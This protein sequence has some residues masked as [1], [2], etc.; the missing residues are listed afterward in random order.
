[1]RVIPVI[2]LM[3]GQVVRGVAGNR[4]EYRPIESQIAIDARPKTVA[5]ALVERFEFQTVY[6]AD[7]DAIRGGSPNLHAWQDISQAG[8][9]LW[10]DAGLG[11]PAACEAVTEMLRSL[12]IEAHIIIGLES[13]RDPND[14]GWKSVLSQLPDLIFSLD[15]KNGVPIHRIN[16]WRD[17]SASEIARSAHTRGFS[18][19]I[20]LDLADVGTS[21]GTRTLAL[22]RL[23]A[24]ELPSAYIIAGGGVRGIDDLH[25]LASAGCSAALVA[26]ALHDGRLS[27]EDIRQM[28]S[29]SVPR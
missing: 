25:A 19:M 1:M 14:E 13:L 2:D 29:L 26:S 6:I 4:S 28:E 12:K 10:I 18:N 23:L 22:C 9:S 16:A 15:L 17:W 27:A 11:D 5:R 3:D 20:V 8:L 24:Q 21:Q 7:L